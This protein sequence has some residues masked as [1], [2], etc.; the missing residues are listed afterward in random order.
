[1]MPLAMGRH[2]FTFVAALSAALFVGVGALWVRSYSVTDSVSVG[3]ESP[4]LLVTTAAGGLSVGRYWFDRPS[5]P[6]PLDEGYDPNAVVRHRVYRDDKPHYPIWQKPRT[7]A[8]ALGFHWDAETINTIH[9]GDIT[10][11]RAVVPLWA[12]ATALLVLPAL[13]LA[14]WRR[15]S[16]RA[17]AGHCVTCGYDLR[18]SPDGCPECG[19]GTTTA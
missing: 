14:S 4:T 1:M 2:L 11:R 13:R 3:R 19:A 10:R 15:R 17:R 12:V 5:M 16:R 18:S 7:P 6:D 8:N 9:N